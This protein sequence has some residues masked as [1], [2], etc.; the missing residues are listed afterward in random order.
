M[1]QPSRVTF[2][3]IIVLVA[4][5]VGFAHLTLVKRRAALETAPI[6]A[7]PSDGKFDTVVGDETP[8]TPEW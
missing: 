8:F 4:T 7:S 1:K 2:V 5:G 3:L 6:D